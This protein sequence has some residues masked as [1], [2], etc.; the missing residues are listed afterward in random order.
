MYANEASPEASSLWVVFEPVASTLNWPPVTV[1]APPVSEAATLL[2]S[3]SD[4]SDWLPLTLMPPLPPKLTVP[5]VASRL[6]PPDRAI[7]PAEIVVVPTNVFAAVSESVPTPCFVSEPVPLM[8]SPSVRSFERLTTRPAVFK[9]AIG[10]A[11]LPAVPPSPRAIVPPVTVVSPVYVLALVSVSVPAPAFVT[12]PLPEITAPNANESERLN[13]RTALFVM[14][15]ATE[16]VVEP[17]PIANV[18]PVIV[19]PP[20]YVLAFVSVSVPE[21]LLVSEPP[22]LPSAVAHVTA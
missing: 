6:L 5:L 16:P 14:S 9:S 8:T 21:P 7:V 13:A 10:P 12:A 1:T 17:L 3:D 11:T 2:A 15:P 20:S 18:P 4:D 19:V 22:L